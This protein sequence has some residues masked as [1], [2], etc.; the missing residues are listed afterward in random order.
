VL[1]VDDEPDAVEL[2]AIV[3]GQSGAEVRTA[4]SVAEAM[5]IVRAWTPDLI[6]SDIGMPREDGFSLARKLR[7]LGAPFA[8]I[9]AIALSAFARREDADAAIRAGF[10][11]HIAKPVD[12]RMLVRVAANALAGRPP[13]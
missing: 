9:P 1:A 7:A 10:G 11:W 6:V 4:S 13:R 3:L 12:P 2:V 8:D 5:D